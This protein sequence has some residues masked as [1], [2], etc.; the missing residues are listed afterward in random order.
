MLLLPLEEEDSHPRPPHTM[1]R[2]DAARAQL[3]GC[4]HTGLFA[5]STAPELPQVL[6]S[7]LQTVVSWLDTAR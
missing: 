1:E 6:G 7:Q 5:T 2:A 4:E 3:Q